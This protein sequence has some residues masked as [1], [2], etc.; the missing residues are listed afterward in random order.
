[1]AL[2]AAPRA[3]GSR[4]RARAAAW[5]ANPDNARTDFRMIALFNLAVGAILLFVPALAHSSSFV[6]LMHL[7]AGVGNLHV[8][9]GCAYLAAGTLGLAGLS[10]RNDRR[11]GRLRHYAWLLAGTLLV[12]WI[13]GVLEATGSIPGVLLLL[14]A[15]AWYT[16]T[17]ARLELPRALRR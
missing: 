5:L 1:M 14:L 9:W 7:V 3:S 4:L 17:A 2:P 6:V 8:A 10:V 15:L 13:V 16:V 12:M 11:A